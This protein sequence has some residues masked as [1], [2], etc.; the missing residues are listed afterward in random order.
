MDSMWEPE[1][2]VPVSCDLCGREASGITYLRADGMRVTEC[3]SCGL[4]F[5]N[6]RPVNELVNRLYDERYFTGQG[7]RKGVGITC[8]D[9]A[10][11]PILSATSGQATSRQIRLLERVVGPLHGKRILEVGCATGDLLLEIKNRGAN[12]IGLEISEFAAGI[13]RQRGLDVMAGTLEDYGPRTRAVF[14]LLVALEVIEHVIS[15][16]RFLEAARDVLAAGGHCLISTPNYACARQF[17]N[18]WMG[19]TRSFEHLWFFSP[20]SLTRMA[21]RCGLRMTYWETSSMPGGSY[22]SLRRFH[23]IMSKTRKWRSIVRQIGLARACRE[24]LAGY[25]FDYYPFG[26]GHTLFALLEK[27]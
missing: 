6:P 20:I 23:E 16:A 11:R 7:E 2:L 4:A 19:F 5:L 25:N 9:E 1:E 24:R 15:P 13:A 22:D 8:V 21:L 3:P 14:D 12:A 17:G 27:A 26:T 18:Q 10:R